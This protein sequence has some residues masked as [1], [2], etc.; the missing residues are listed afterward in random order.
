VR[1][2]R[3]DELVEV[4]ALWRETRGAL[5]KTDDQQSLERLLHRDE[6]AL[7]VA[8]QGCHIVGSLI[9]AWDGWRASMYRLTV[10][11]SHQRQGIAL[12]LIQAGERVLRSRGARRVTALVREEDPGAVA[13]WRRA[14]YQHDEGTGRFVKGLGD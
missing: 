10:H 2:C 13:V 4:L 11:P 5:G 14:A 9:A 7:L 12:E 1:S 6:D 3:S 8:V